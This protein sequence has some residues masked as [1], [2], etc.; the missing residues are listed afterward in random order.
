MNTATM[1]LIK[2]VNVDAAGVDKDNLAEFKAGWV[3]VMSNP[4][5][6]GLYKIG[7]TA[8]NPHLRAKQL[9]TT[10]VPA[11]YKVMY[12]FQHEDYKEYEM[13]L[14][15]NFD[16]DRAY[17][18]REFFDVPLENIIVA[19]HEVDLLEDPL[20]EI[21]HPSFSEKYIELKNKIELRK[22]RERLHK[23]EEERK[24]NER[25]AYM[26]EVSAREAVAT[27]VGFNYDD[28]CKWQRAGYSWEFLKKMVESNN[29]NQKKMV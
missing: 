25:R 12:A 27:M 20:N 18:E 24:I 10:G 22:N 3:Y 23:I 16:D 9:R 26:K 29:I 2:K 1:P 14:H 6:E 17:N 4:S 28:Y 21:I 13:A 19:I 8:G 7:C 5:M 11:P 15:H